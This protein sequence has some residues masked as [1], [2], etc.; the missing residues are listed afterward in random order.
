MIP[1]RQSRLLILAVG[2]L[3]AFQIAVAHGRDVAVCGDDHAWAPIPTDG[4][5]DVGLDG[6]S[7]SGSENGS[8]PCGGETDW[9]GD[10]MIPWHHDCPSSLVDFVLFAIWLLFW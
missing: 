6:G 5:D 8:V 9:P 3:L 10:Y 7:W 1:L 4:L 2:V